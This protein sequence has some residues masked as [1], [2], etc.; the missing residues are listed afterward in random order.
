MR[1]LCTQELCV[2]Q[3]AGVNFNSP[4]TPGLLNSVA[5]ATT[6]AKA[7]VASFTLGYAIGTWLNDKFDLSTKIVDALDP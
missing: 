2:V 6:V 4:I 7:V 3:G 1:E 5:N